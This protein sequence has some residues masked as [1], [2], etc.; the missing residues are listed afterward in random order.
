VNIRRFRALHAAGATFAEIDR[1]YG[2]GAWF[3]S[4]WPRTRRRAA[5][6]TVSSGHPA[7]IDRAVCGAD[8]GVAAIDLVLKGTVVHE[9]LVAEYGFTGNYQRVKMFLAEA[10]PRLAAELEESDDIT[11]LTDTPADSATA[12]ANSAEGAAA[13]GSLCRAVTASD[14][15]SFGRRQGGR[16]AEGQRE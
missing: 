8:R 9:R 4:I 14:D 13:T 7:S 6:I 15:H 11:R 10:R 3:V 2:C 16:H 5:D 1:E 12:C